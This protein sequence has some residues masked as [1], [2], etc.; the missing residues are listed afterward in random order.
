MYK[1]YKF[2]RHDVKIG[3][4]GNREHWLVICHHLSS[5][6]PS[7]RIC[8]RV[9]YQKHK[10]SSLDLFRVCVI[11]AKEQEVTEL[12]HWMLAV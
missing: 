3:L 2:L 5:F 6:P 7:V 8:H 9:E 1:T 10:M 11:M 12:S 4:S